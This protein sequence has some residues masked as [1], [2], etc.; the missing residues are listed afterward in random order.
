MALSWGKA[1]PLLAEGVPLGRSRLG[2]WG[3]PRKAGL[4]RKGRKVVRQ[5]RVAQHP[6]GGG[7]TP[8]HEPPVRCDPS[9][10]PG[11]FRK[12]WSFPGSRCA[13]RGS[14]Q[15]SGVVQTEAAYGPPYWAESK[16]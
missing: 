9:K 1:Q 4:G 13:D 10:G 2:T 14:G 12:Q 6:E 11:A 3:L 16:N 15:F 5:Q 7:G 8:A